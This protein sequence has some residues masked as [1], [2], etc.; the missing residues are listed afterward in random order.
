MLP[1]LLLG[2]LPTR[3]RL[4]LSFALSAVVG[5]LYSLSTSFGLSAFTVPL[6]IV[7]IAVI[8]RSKSM[9][10]P[11]AGTVIGASVIALPGILSFL[12]HEDSIRASMREPTELSSL[13]DG[14][15]YLIH[16]APKLTAVGGVLVAAAAV[17]AALTRRLQ[18]FGLL[19][20][21]YLLA[22]APDVLVKSIFAPSAAL[23]Q[24]LLSVNYYS[25]LVAPI[26][27]CAA[28]AVGYG[29]LPRR[30][31]SILSAALM[32]LVGQM[33]I[34]KVA[35]QRERPG[36]RLSELLADP[37]L[38]SVARQSNDTH[39][40][41][42]MLTTDVA[43]LEHFQFRI[44]RPLP[45]YLYAQRI[46][47]SDGYAS[48]MSYDYATLWSNVLRSKQGSDLA[49]PD[50]FRQA[51]LELDVRDYIKEGADGCFSQVKN[52]ALP[53]IN[54]DLLALTATRFIV[55]YLDVEDSRLRLKRP[56]S[57][58]PIVCRDR[59]FVGGFNVYELAAA[60]E[61]VSLARSVEVLKDAP[62]VLARMRRSAGAKD[63]AAAFLA[64]ADA[65]QLR[66]RNRNGSTGTVTIVED[67][68]DRVSARVKARASTLLIVRDSF[69]PAA[70][71]LIDG[72]PA[73]F[74]RA[75]YVY[76][77]IPVAAGESLVEIRY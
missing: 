44:P 1:A 70:R 59:R 25:Y 5:A 37:A 22:M 27:L 42:A 15:S 38:E 18:D 33:A 63:R 14:L 13:R 77:A 3:R 51:Y 7:W 43:S 73:S 47:S 2:E 55:S 60:A 9:A 40:R 11:I 8:V 56:R 52:V 66:A 64:S 6:A 29:A 74:V 21:L 75:N 10:W 35:S 45:A 12:Q 62:A 26:F 65:K 20:L 28:L 34:A 57:P 32:V 39:Q 71:V 48:S 54:T 49:A 68:P 24:L 23:P 36:M 41:A 72:K 4:V 61:R 69:V 19:C 67:T 30:E 53:D 50:V 31:V 16:R 46:R 76:M 17:A 58:G